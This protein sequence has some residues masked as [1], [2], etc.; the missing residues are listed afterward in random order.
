MAA[1][2]IDFDFIDEHGPQDYRGTF[3]VAPS[4]L[5]RDEV[6]GISPVTI[7]TQVAPSETAGEYIADG[8]VN[9]TADYTC[10]RCLEPYPIANSS[11]FHVRFRPRPAVA[12]EEE[13][14]ITEAE[15]LDVEFYSD[16]SVP[17]RDL[18]VEQVQLSIPMKPLCEENCLGLCAH[19]GANRNRESCKCDEAVTDG[20]WGALQDIRDQL[21]KKKNV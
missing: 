14:E 16:R 6:A 3:D 18:A 11:S 17:L 5:D 12:E 7:E 19:C 2:I 1:P 10:S 8:T 9:F 20:R 4:E 13:I 15:E 21:A